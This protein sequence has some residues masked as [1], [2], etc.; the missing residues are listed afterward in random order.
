MA[1][2]SG[3]RRRWILGNVS[4]PIFHQM[5]LIARRWSAAAEEPVA[6]DRSGS[7]APSICGAAIDASL[8]EAMVRRCGAP[9]L[10]TFAKRLF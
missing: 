9:S 7:V 3:G 8:R 4:H 5:L 1:H 2:V 10:L 6:V